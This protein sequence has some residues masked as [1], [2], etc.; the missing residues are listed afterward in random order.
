M[1]AAESLL[2]TGKVKT[3]EE[4]FKYSQIHVAGADLPRTYLKDDLEDTILHEFVH[5][6]TSRSLD[7]GKRG[8]L[9]EGTEFNILTKD[10]AQVNNHLVSEY[11]KRRDAGELQRKRQS[12]A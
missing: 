3:S 5:A 10:L 11:R 1:A 2:T 9:S 12:Q 8:K 6:V 7:L 4:L